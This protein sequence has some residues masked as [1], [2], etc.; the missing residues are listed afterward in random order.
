MKADL[1][2]YQSHE[3]SGGSKHVLGVCVCVCVW[4]SA[5]ESVSVGLLMAAASALD[6]EADRLCVVLVQP[7]RHLAH[8][9]LLELL[10]VSVL[11]RETRMQAMTTFVTHHVQIATT[12]KAKEIVY[13]KRFALD[14]FNFHCRDKLPADPFDIRCYYG[15]K[16]SR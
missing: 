15:T 14:Y 4:V 5:R 9:F 7:V 6:V 12:I 1:W 8:C 10:A 2:L 3:S 16:L 13:K 11:L